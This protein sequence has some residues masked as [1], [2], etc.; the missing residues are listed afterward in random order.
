MMSRWITFIAVPSS[1]LRA[2]RGSGR[3]AFCSNRTDVWE[4]FGPAVIRDHRPA[5]PLPSFIDT[6]VHFPQTNAGDADAGG[7]LLEWLNLCTFPSE[8]RFADDAARCPVTYGVRS[9]R[10]ELARDQMLFALLMGNRESS[11][12]EVYVMGRRYGLELAA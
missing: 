2:G 6:H 4:R 3:I 12:V 7:Q 11:I 10:P 1:T 8:S 5:F 9:A